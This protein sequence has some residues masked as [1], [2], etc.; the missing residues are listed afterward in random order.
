MAAH[1]APIISTAARNNVPVIYRVST[2][3]R[4]GGLLSY[5]STD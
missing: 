5:A 2:Y 1:C 4:E 3:A